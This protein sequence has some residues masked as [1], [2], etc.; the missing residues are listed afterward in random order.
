MK[1][2]SSFRQDPSAKNNEHNTWNLRA[3]L[4][5]KNEDRRM[6]GKQKKG[7][8]AQITRYLLLRNQRAGLV[9][10]GDVLGDEMESNKREGESGE[11]TKRS[12][13]D[14]FRKPYYEI[15]IYMS[16]SRLGWALLLFVVCYFDFFFFQ[17][18]ASEGWALP[19]EV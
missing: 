1:R 19:V 13:E 17:Y 2:L 15:D 7:K 10:G 8:R 11:G 14:P 16:V 12:E 6:K 4:E 5:K 18:W 3:Q 9:Q